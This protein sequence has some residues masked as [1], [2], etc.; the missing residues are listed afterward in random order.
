LAF[1]RAGLSTLSLFTRLKQESVSRF[2]VVTFR[3]S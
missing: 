2:V 3:N 1:L